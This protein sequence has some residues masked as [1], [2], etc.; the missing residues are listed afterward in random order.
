MSSFRKAI[1]ASV[2]LLLAV[3]AVAQTVGEASGQRQEAA[4]RVQANFNFF[5]TGPSG[6]SEEAR[7]SR[8]KA[9]RLVYEMA[10][11]ECDL[12]R[13]VLAKDCRMESVS[14]NIG[15]QQGQHQPEGYTVNGSVS[16]QITL[17]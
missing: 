11:H 3:P 16:L 13:E 12:L 7:K 2:T 8:D 4:V 1:I 9:R 5:M 6:D 14:S 10:V 17:K 15:L